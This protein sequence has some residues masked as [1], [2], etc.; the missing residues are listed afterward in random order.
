MSNGSDD[1]G[2][3]GTD[4]DRAGRHHASVRRAIRA[5]GVLAAS[6]PLDARRIADA[7]LAGPWT[8]YAMTRR[9]HDALPRS[10]RWL[11][12]LAESVRATYAKPP[13]RLVLIGAVAAGP[14]APGWLTGRPAGTRRAA[15][16]D[17]PSWPVPAW[18]GIGELAGDLGVSIGALQWFADTQGRLRRAGDDR[19]THYRRHAVAGAHGSLRLIEAPKWQLRELQRRVLHEVLDV[20]P[21]HD[22]AHGYRAG[23]GVL[24]FAAPHVGRPVLCHLD[25]SAFFAGITAAR[26]AGVFR[27]LGYADPLAR[28]LAGLTTTIT[29]AG[30][31]RRLLPGA[32]R[33]RLR[34]LLRAPHLPQGAPTSP[35]LANLVAYR[36]DAR[37][38]G[39]AH[40]LG[41]SYTRYA[42]DLAFSGPQWIGDRLPPVVAGIV[43]AEGFT[44]NVRKI[45]VR[46]R[47]GAQRLTG[48][49]VNDR[50]NTP[51]DE[52]DVLRAILHGCV[53]RGPAGENRAD[54]PDFRAH[55]TGRIAWVASVNPVRGAKLQALAERIDWA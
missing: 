50:L 41:I 6:S 29:P 16:R 7:L 9:L 13:P 52:Y 3:D 45:G 42:D 14:P 15:Q 17:R 49:V 18:A 28:V 27:L 20:V 5:A 30:E 48:L 8:A 25:L 10:R 51:R 46:G 32:D 43:A 35:A 47:S 53:V 19:L 23:R 44:M 33:A 34:H 12:E 55:L 21:P 22:A 4:P 40:S 1:T 36:L 2:S 26:V 31:C 38:A 11:A 39:L 54:R 24:T 37:L